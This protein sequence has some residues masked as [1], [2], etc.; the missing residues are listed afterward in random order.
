MVYEPMVVQDLESRTPLQDPGLAAN[1]FSIAALLSSTF[2][3]DILEATF[4]FQNTDF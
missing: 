1:L 2:L 4:S 3:S